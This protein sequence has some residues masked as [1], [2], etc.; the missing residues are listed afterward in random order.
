MTQQ[1]VYAKV[2]F[3][4]MEYSLY[5]W[6]TFITLGNTALVTFKKSICY[7]PDI[8]RRKFPS[9]ILVILMS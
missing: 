7:W 6:H 3:G 5:Q 2:V 9:V 4:D 8:W 1:K